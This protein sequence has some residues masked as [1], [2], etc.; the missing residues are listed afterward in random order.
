MVVLGLV[1]GRSGV[2]LDLFWGHSEVFVRLFWGCLRFF[3]GLFWGRFGLLL[4]LFWIALWVWEDICR[5]LASL[6]TLSA[7]RGEHRQRRQ[8][9]SPPTT[10]RWPTIWG[11]RRQEEREAL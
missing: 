5:L 6:K 9:L 2:V 3:L 10:T 11:G 4:G 1:W 8:I 7:S